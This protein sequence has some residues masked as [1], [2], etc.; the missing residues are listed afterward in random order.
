LHF[1][2]EVA[3]SHNLVAA[4]S[5]P[6]DIYAMG[7]QL[8]RANTPQVIAPTKAAFLNIFFIVDKSYDGLYF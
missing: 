6:H 3:L 8:P 5:L 1:Y 2:L 4:F 7:G